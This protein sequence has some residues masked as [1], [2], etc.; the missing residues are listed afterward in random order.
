[1]LFQFLVEGK[2]SP[3]NIGGL[4]RGHCAAP[5]QRRVCSF[6]L[7]DLVEYET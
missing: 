2:P 6:H 4:G 3:L 7:L 1:M 5:S